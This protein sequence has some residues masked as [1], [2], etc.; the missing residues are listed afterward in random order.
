MVG[1]NLRTSSYMMYSSNFD[2]VHSKDISLYLATLF[3]SPD[4]N[5]GVIQCSCH[6][7]GKEYLML[8]GNK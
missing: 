2:T 5:M 4:L 6:S 8:W 3:L 7:D 1:I